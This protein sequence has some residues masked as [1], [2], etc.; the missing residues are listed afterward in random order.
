MTTW[1]A[2]LGKKN[3]KLQ[4]GI[5][6]LSLKHPAQVPR[7]PFDSALGIKTKFKKMGGENL[8]K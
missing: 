4:F 7:W 6:P 2:K 8:K 5:L 1:I 3:W